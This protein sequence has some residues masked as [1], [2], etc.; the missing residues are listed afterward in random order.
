MIPPMSGRPA[1]LS[2]LPRRRGRNTGSAP[3]TV[4][5]RALCP[6]GVDV[7]WRAER[8]DTEWPGSASTVRISC[9]C[10]CPKTTQEAA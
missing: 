3:E 1:L 8:V 2:P 10:T 9:Q 4:T 6:H 7:E 5:W